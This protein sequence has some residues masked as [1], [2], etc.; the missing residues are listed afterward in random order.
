MS[1][2][3]VFRASLLLWTVIL[4]AMLVAGLKSAFW[5]LLWVAFSLVASGITQLAVRRWNVLIN[6]RTHAC[7]RAQQGL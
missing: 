7:R 5:P 3:D 1:K 6:A 4:A 2:R